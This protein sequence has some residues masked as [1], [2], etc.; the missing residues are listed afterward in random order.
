MTNEEIY[1]MAASG[2]DASK[3]AHFMGIEITEKWPPAALIGVIHKLVDEASRNNDYHLQS[4]RLMADLSRGR[5][6]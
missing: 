5:S 6:L 2:R 4:L 1:D 3:V